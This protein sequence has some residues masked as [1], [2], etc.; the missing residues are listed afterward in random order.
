MAVMEMRHRA[1]EAFAAVLPLVSSRRKIGVRLSRHD[2]LDARQF[3]W[4]HF[5]YSCG[6]LADFDVTGNVSPARSAIPMVLRATK[7]R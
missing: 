4:D 7:T 1:G 3:H 2:T 6:K 5:G